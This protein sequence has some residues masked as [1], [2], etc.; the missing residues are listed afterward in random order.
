M[1]Q[2]Y[3]QNNNLFMIRFQSTVT[4]SVVL[5]LLKCVDEKEY[6]RVDFSECW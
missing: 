6:A 1:N 5:M 3:G 4:Q 2:D